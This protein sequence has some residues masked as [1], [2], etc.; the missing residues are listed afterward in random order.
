MVWVL[1]VVFTVGVT[2]HSPGKQDSRSVGMYWTERE[3][4][5]ASG[6]A[7]LNLSRDR[8][9]PE[10]TRFIRMRCVAVPQ[11]LA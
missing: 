5:E 8:L 7:Y 11:E 3:C 4:Q 6:R 9:H 1:F 10:G 2:A